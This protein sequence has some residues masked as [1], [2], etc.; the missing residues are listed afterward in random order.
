MYAAIILTKKHSSIRT[1]HMFHDNITTN[2]CTMSLITFLIKLEIFS[3][4]VFLLS[5]LVYFL[6]YKEFQNKKPQF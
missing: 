3:R 2:I 1:L 6:Q 5:V 4:K